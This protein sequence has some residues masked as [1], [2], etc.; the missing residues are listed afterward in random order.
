MRHPSKKDYLVTF[1]LLV[2][3][4][5]PEKTSAA[6]ITNYVTLTPKV[7]YTQ[8]GKTGEQS[9]NNMYRKDQRGTRDNP[10]KYVAFTTPRSIYLGYQKFNLPGTIDRTYI[11]S[12]SVRVNYKG[13]TKS[14]Q[15]WTWY[16]YNWSTARW[17]KIGN[18]ATATNLRWSYFKFNVIDP[19]RFIHPTS[20]E[21][22]LRLRSSNRSG[23]AKIDYSVIRLGY[24]VPLPPPP[25]GSG[26]TIAG[27][28]LFPSNNYWNTPVDTLPVHARSSAWI[29]SIGAG[30]GFHMDFGSGTWDG[31]PIGI[32]FNVVAGSLPRTNVSF[33]YPDESD[34]GP[35][36][37]PD[38]P[39]RE[40]G[41]DHHVLIVDQDNCTLYELY[42]ADLSGGS[43]S[44]GSGAI[45]DL[46]SNALRPVGWT[47]ADAAGLPIL[48]GL[49]RYEEV[50]AGEIKHAI[51][52]TAPQ[53]QQAYL[54]P[55]RHFASSN[56]DPNLPPMGARFRLKAA[57]DISG[58]PAEMQVILRAMKKYGIVLADNGSPWYISG[59]PNENWDNDMLH[60]LDNLQGSDFEA[61]DT[62]I[63]MQDVNSGRTS[64]DIW[65]PAVGS[66]W[67]WQLSGPLD[68]SVNASV[69]DLDLEDTSAATVASLH[70]QGKKVIC[71][72]SIGSWEDWRADAGQFPSQVLGNDYDGW[73]GE[74]WLDI[75]Q[76]DLLAPIMRARLDLC[77]QKGFDAV[78]PDNMDGYTN[79]TGF[80]LTYQHQV[81]YNTWFANEAH[82]RGLSVGMKNDS[83]QVGDLQPYFD[84]ALT[85]DCFDQG[86]CSDMS[87]FIQAGKPVFAA[88][89]TDTGIT[90]NDFCPQAAS[91][92][93]SAILKHRNLDAQRWVCP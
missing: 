7:Y 60:L 73:P 77:K 71:Y 29:N 1:F 82:Q 4:L 13:Y 65:Q 20:G 5:L 89:Y 25:S 92:Q 53:T 79:N 39:L 88:E 12:M 54:W 18:N 27:C 78:E 38:S 9:V 40:W 59:S 47:S 85:E 10:A 72:I 69:F 31:G 28:P 81:A 83:E 66:S 32:P 43:W 44:A 87:P 22:R 3:L 68:A 86:W 80:P 42:D 76:I 33:Y 8:R 49:V 64:A 37:I 23:D 36:P 17:V 34:P 15:T 74:K 21:I 6:G 50:A 46:N 16:L 45:W 56:A 57:I 70:S 84:W 51:R 90:L 11:A 52:F 58:Y 41:S 63:L 26:P 67:Q 75:R 62:S 14:R 61:V 93:F 19:K 24:S 91:L 55:A 2:I 48:P 35:Y 30:T